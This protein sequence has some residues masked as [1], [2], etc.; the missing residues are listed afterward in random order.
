MSNFYTNSFVTLGFAQNKASVVGA[1]LVSFAMALS[2]S[3]HPSGISRPGLICH[4]KMIIT[5]DYVCL[6][7]I[8]YTEIEGG[9]ID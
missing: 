1:D 5:I 6:L 9:I 3:T 2:A 8:C 4:L 7:L